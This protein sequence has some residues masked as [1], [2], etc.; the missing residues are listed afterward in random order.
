M[1]DRPV[2]F[3]TLAAE[4]VFVM[5]CS[6]GQL[7]FA[8]FLGDVVVNQV[9]FVEVMRISPRNTPWIVGSFLLASGIAV[10]IFGSLAD[11]TN[12]KWLV[13]ALFGWLTI[14]NL[15]GTFSVQPSLCLVLRG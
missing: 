14:W 11:L 2:E 13:V 9:T 7:L 6:M 1:Q 5:L 12:K 10:V 4:L 3:S 15:V 8:V